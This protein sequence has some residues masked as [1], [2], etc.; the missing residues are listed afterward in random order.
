MKFSFDW[1]KELSGTSLSIEDA[2]ALLSAKAFES[3]VTET[4][5]VLDID[6]LPNRPDALSHLGVA[7]EISALTGSRFLAPTY[8]WRVSD[9]AVKEV[10]IDDLVA[11]P[12][13][14][15]L[16]VRGIKVGPSPAWLVERLAAC[17]QQSINNVVDVTNYVMLELGQ[18]MHAFDLSLVSRIQVRHA[19]AGESLTALD[20]ART[21]YALDETMLVIADGDTALAIA[22]IKGGVGTAISDETTEVFLEAAN[23]S[24]ESVR[25]TSRKL[26]L[27]TDAS[28]RFGYGVDPNLTAPAL[29]R[30]AQLL[31]QVANGEADGGIVDVYPHPVE[32]RTLVLDPAYVHSLLGLTLQES[33]LQGI[34]ESLGFEIQR[35]D[36]KFHV[37]VPTRRSDVVAQEDCIEEIGRVFGFDA[38][39]SI[40]PTLPIYGEHSWVREDEAVVW[41]EYAYMRERSAIGR[42]LA[43]AGYSEVYNYAFVSDEIVALL[44][45]E[46]LHELAQPQSSEYRWLRS[47]LVPRLLLNARDNL[48]F[49][50]AVHLFE[51]GHVFNSIGQGKEP[52]R[53]GLVIARHNSP[54]ELFF[55]LKGA[56]SMVLERLGVTDAYFDDAEPFS[57]DVGAVHATLS[58]R[59]ACIRDGNGKI[60]GFIGSVHG[61][62]AEALKLKGSAAVAE[63]DLRAL[64]TAAQYEREF[65]PL[66]KYP[67][68]I[69]DIAVMVSV[70]TKIDS[71]IQTVHNADTSGLIQDVDVFDI[72]VP[73]GKEKI[74][75]EGDT[76]KYGKSVAFHVT[77]RSDERTLTDKDVDAVEAEIRAALQEK[78]GAQMR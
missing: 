72:F 7:R 27:R 40:A 17:G 43:G 10:S 70:D 62:I 47:S 1:I 48:R 16:A 63:L 21:K 25:A 12:R 74:E 20:D 64:I 67:E 56:V 18:P 51:T 42:L 23:F 75:E 4:P 3:V 26:G 22:G 69:R 15:G 45:L 24:P 11:C 61:R 60:I 14:S 52:S 73:T 32:P 28:I 8:E 66:P 65:E 54:G 35:H 38:V 19:R 76:P 31:R 78:L 34:L 41:D 2:A 58:G 39:P 59:R 71:I 36:Q 6:I 57:W 53:L 5:G 50:D 29:M 30:A 9:R 49:T 55:E 13:Y 33:Q 68:V 77:L 46:H 44:K 37:T